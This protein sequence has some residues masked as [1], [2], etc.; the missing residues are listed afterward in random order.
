MKIN[1]HFLSY[2]AQFLLK[3]K[4]FQTK[5]VEEI[6]TH[7][8]LSVT[9]F[10]SKIVPF[11]RKCRAGYKWQYGAIW[12]M[13][14]VFWITKSTNTHSEYVIL[15]AFPLQPLLEERSS[16]LRYPHT[17][18]HFSCV[19][20]YNLSANIFFHSLICDSVHFT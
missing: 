6:K 10:F 11:I 12:H 19:F 20:W 16:M 1:I 8:L 18:C 4:L 15:I 3:W 13:R 17:I 9:F 14:I 7:I 5:V 2:L